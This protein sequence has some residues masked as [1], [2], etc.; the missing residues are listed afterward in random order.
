MRWGLLPIPSGLFFGRA[1]HRLKPMLEAKARATLIILALFAVPAAAESTWLQVSSPS[2]DIFTDA[3]ENSARALLDRFE[4][5]N[6]I[7]R[8]SNVAPSPPRLRVF[9]FS[10]VRDFEKYRPTPSTAGFFRGDDDQDVIVLAE[11][12]QLKYI[13][14]HEYLHRVIQHASPLL[15]AWLNEGLPEFYSTIS[16]SGNKVRVGAVVERN[17]LLLLHEPWLDAED[18]A[19]SNR[20]DGRIFYAESWALVHML[21]LSPDFSRGMPEFVKLLTEGVA[22]A[23]AFPKAFG[24]SMEQALVALHSYMRAPKEISLPAPPADASE[25]YQTTRLSPIDAALALADLALRTNHPDLARTLFEKTAKENP[26]SPAAVAGLGALALSAN[27]KD[28][29]RREFERAIAMGLNDAR[30]YFELAALNHDD[31]LIEKAL[32]I[33]S[34]FAEAHFLL[35]VRLTDAGNFASA[36][37]HLEKAVALQPR[38]FTYWNALAYVQAKSGDRQ[39]AAESARRA[40][41]LA[42]TPEE[43][44]MAAALMQLAAESSTLREKKPDA[45]TPPSWQNPKGDTRVDGTLT[46]VD[47]SADPVRLVLSAEGK[48]IELTVR[49]PAEVVLINAEGVSTTLVCG[50]QSLPVAVE[51]QASSKNVTRIEFKGVVIIKR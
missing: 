19:L 42:H 41:I 24:V 2:I 13:A 11:G 5:L 26:D 6:R 3:G 23:E 27:Q 10:S 49:N 40:S 43:E 31:A 37:A 16:V 1:G 21:S 44:H 30:T 29:A 15:P 32:T 39:A 36:V 47:C 4:T 50:G 12:N 35:G 45:V 33:D 48:N 38:R 14:S 28:D 17:R 9:I 22:Q 18:L 8:E 46:E 25:K 51:Y 20:A 34:N 7:F